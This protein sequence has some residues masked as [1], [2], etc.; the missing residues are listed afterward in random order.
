MR[1]ELE[2][3]LWRCGL[4]SGKVTVLLAVA[5]EY[6]HSSADERIASQRQGRERLELAAAEAARATAKGWRACGS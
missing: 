2:A 1:E 3:R 4:P 5:D 6:A